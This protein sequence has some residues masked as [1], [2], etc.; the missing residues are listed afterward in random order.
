MVLV[1]VLNFFARSGDLARSAAVEAVR[2][3]NHD[4]DVEIVA[5][6]SA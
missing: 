6:T 1:E 2:D 5:Q 3:L 4:P